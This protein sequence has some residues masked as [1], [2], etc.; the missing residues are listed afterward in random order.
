[1]GVMGA[2]ER[3]EPEAVTVVVPCFNEEPGIAPLAAAL[4]RLE[5]QLAPRYAARFVFVDDGSTDATHRLLEETFGG[6]PGCTVLRHPQN[7][8]LVAAILTGARHAE[9][10]VVASI[11]S[12][13]TYDP[14]VLTE[15]LPRLEPGVD[16]VTASPYHRLGRVNNVPG[17]RLLLSKGLSQLY[18]LTL[19]N[20]LA[21]YTACVRV[22]RRSALLALD[23]QNARFAGTAEMIGLLDLRGG[24]VVEV[25]A[26]LDVR[27]HGY[28]KMNIA[29]TVGDHL[30]LLRRLWSVKL[31]GR[32]RAARDP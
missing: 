30:R 13:C 6:R 27:R 29:R 18:R 4:E 1:M 7:R 19:D 12:D 26:V 9:T 5:A 22:Y 32:A 14:V 15:L 21:T 23:I 10:E 16:M 20:K 3:G 25:P 31:T 11:D 8:G 28:S 17:W 24:R 2:Q